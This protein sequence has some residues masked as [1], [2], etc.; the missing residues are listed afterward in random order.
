MRRGVSEMGRLETLE[1]W[2]EDHVL[3][4]CVTALITL[5]ILIGAVCFIDSMHDDKAEWNDFADQMNKDTG[6]YLDKGYNG[7]CGYIK[8]IGSDYSTTITVSTSYDS[9]INY[10]KVH[11][12]DRGVVLDWYKK[13]TNGVVTHTSTTYI[14]YES[15][16]YIQANKVV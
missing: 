13:T 6:Y 8:T 14:P 4:V 16:C 9:S 15:I 7:T 11:A 10:C 1:D 2:L 5:L 3:I 12:N